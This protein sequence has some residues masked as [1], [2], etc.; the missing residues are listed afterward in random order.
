[1]VELIAKAAMSLNLPSL[2][3]QLDHLFCSIEYSLSASTV[4]KPAELI[5]GV[6]LGIKRHLWSIFPSVIF[7]PGSENA[8]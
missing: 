8:V 1:M 7:V 5:C 2:L 3:V 6:N 4:A